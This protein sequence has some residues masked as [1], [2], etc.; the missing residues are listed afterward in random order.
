MIELRSLQ[1]L[2]NKVQSFTERYENCM[3]QEFESQLHNTKHES[4]LWK[5]CV[6]SF[7]RVS[8]TM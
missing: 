5:N 4:I 7:S 6:H 2:E 8:E 3:K 1:M